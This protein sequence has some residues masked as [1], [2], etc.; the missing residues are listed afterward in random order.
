MFQLPQIALVLFLVSLPLTAAPAA[1]AGPAGPR[2]FTIGTN[3]SGLVDYGTELPFVDLMHS[4]RVWYTKDDG[5]PSTPWDTQAAPLLAY[6]PDGYPTK[7]PQTVEGRSFPQKVATIWADASGWPDGIYTVEF[8]GKGRLSV[9]YSVAQVKRVSA[10]KITF[11]LTRPRAPEVP[12]VQLVIDASD[13]SDPVRNI[14][15]LMPGSESTYQKQPFNPRWL[16]KLKAFTSVRLMD[17]GATNHWGQSDPWTWDDPSLFSWSQRQTLDHYT[18]ADGRG[19]PYEM[20][21]RLMNDQ[22]LDG[23]VCVPH[24]ASPEFVRSMAILFH[25]TLDPQR[26]LTVEYSNE[27]WNWMF[28]QAQWLKTYGHPSAT[29]I[30][31]HRDRP[32]AFGYDPV[33]TWPER[34][35]GNIQD[36]LDVWTSVYGNDLARLNRV[37]GLQTGW[38]DVSQRIAYNLKPGSFDGVSPTY[39]FALSEEADAALDALGPAAKVADAVKWARLS[40]EQN[41]MVW[42]RE[43][44]TSV[45][46]KLSVPMV[47][48]EGG[49]HLTAQPFGEEPTYAQALLDVQRDA[50]MGV[51]YREWFEF[52]K[53]L[54]RGN[55]PLVLMNF[56]FV[57]PRS[58]QYGSWGILETL[59]QDLS[60]TPAPK[61]SAVL[62]AMA[63]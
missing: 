27:N 55:E 31:N 30:A 57:G 42:L 5:N 25:D 13:P 23:W 14:R 17:W 45:A 15:V 28:G 22:G 60:K 44:K 53:T 33:T 50:A 43:L 29:A 41:E 26:R 6:R 32:G 46:D 37:V 61:Y 35:T 12:Q 4:A 16:D 47:F 7:I 9:E 38:I 3:L 40:R 51:L 39:Y 63:W 59:D 52:L 49:Q 36:C 20:M 62:E 2:V 24:R 8:D 58:A 18:W 21:V 19:V 48:Y 56:S 34:I 54:R 10:N 11:A 1:P